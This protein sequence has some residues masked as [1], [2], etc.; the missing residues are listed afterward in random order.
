VV[1]EGADHM[2]PITHPLETAAELG[3]LFARG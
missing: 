1:V 3:R 2:L